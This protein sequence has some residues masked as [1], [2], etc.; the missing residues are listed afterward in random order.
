MT[1]EAPQDLVQLDTFHNI[2]SL[3]G[4]VAVVTGASRGLGLFAASAGCSKVYIISHSPGSLAEAAAALNALNTP[5]KHSEGQ[6][7][8]IA[9][10]VSTVAGLEAIVS[11]V[12]K[13][14]DHVDILVANAGATF[15]GQLED[16]KE[17]DFAQV[18]NVNVNSVFFTIQKFT[19][20]LAAKGTIA[21][22]SRVIMV[23]SVAGVVIGDV[24][25][26][27]TYAYA[28]SKA[29]VVHL[30][31]NLAVELGS[32]HIIV[33]VVAPGMVPSQMSEPLTSR[34]GGLAAV[35]KQVPDQK[36]GSKED[37]A[38]TM[39]FLASRASRHINGATLLLDGGSFLVRGCA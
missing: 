26:Y 11:K 1:S 15:I 31:Q 30:M 18:M 19:P 16:Y 5:S 8:P 37:V 39:V 17:E 28:A 22:P 32:R 10:D 4:K 21:D 38:G 24:G 14:T 13:T 9:G 20:L 36:L 12:R 35:A 29:A 27:G 23:S 33:N 34:H 2:F 3:S 6:A 7:I 25:P